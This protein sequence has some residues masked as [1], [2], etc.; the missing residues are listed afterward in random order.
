M[1]LSVSQKENNQTRINWQKLGTCTEQQLSTGQ[2]NL[3]WLIDLELK[4]EKKYM[5]HLD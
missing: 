3:G 2:E 4:I 1:S 5:D